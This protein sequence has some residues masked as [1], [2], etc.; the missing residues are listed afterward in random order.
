MVIPKT[1][2]YFAEGCWDF[3]FFAELMGVSIEP[4]KARLLAGEQKATEKSSHCSY[5]KALL[6]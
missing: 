4:L 2:V 3:K 1:L 5:P 6:S